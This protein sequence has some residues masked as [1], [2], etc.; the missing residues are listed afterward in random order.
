MLYCSQRRRDDIKGRRG[1]GGLSWI[2]RGGHPLETI[3]SRQIRYFAKLSLDTLSCPLTD[4]ERGRGG[5]GEREGG[6]ESERE[7]GREGKRERWREG[8]RER[9]RERGEREIE[10]ER[11]KERERK[12]EV[13][14]WRER[15]GE[16]LFVGWLVAYRPSNMRVYLRDGSTQT[17]LRAATLR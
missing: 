9:E 2:R 10:G 6:R 7:R 12:R 1:G 3:E 4:R 11:D 14:G 15:E 16:G 17:I 5:G 13:E 8:E